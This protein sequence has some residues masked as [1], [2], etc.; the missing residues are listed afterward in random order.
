MMLLENKVAIV[1]GGAKGMGRAIA[2][3]FAEE[4]A[5]VVVTALHIEGARKVAEE[6]NA[7]GRKG[8]AIKSDI[9]KSAEV[10]DMVEQTIKKFNKIDIL[11]NNAGGVGVTGGDTDTATEE[12]W[13]KIIDVNLKGAFLVTMAVVPYMKKQ[14]SG[15]IINISSMGAVNPA[16]SVLHYHAAKAGMLGLS[17]NLAFELAPLNIH[18]NAIV[19]G[20]I[21]TPFWDSLQPPGPERD[22]FFKALAAKEVPLGR[23]GKPEDIAGPALFLASGMSDYVTGQVIYV[24][25]GQP[26]LAHAATFL[27]AAEQ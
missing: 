3:K 22:K 14:K 19:P 7:L 11:V 23:M 24:A 20:P 8:L 15:K 2:L 6:I 21:E 26:L 9:S 10:K 25:G 1:T 5:D 4:G 17:T 16:V 18:V 13:D 12:D 27:S